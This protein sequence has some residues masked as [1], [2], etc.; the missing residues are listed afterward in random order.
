MHNPAKSFVPGLKAIQKKGDCMPVGNGENLCIRDEWTK[1]MVLFSWQ[2]C[3]D[4][5]RQRSRGFRA[6]ATQGQKPD[7]IFT[8]DLAD[9][10]RCSLIG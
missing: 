10:E 5:G 1:K 7:V 8:R 2:H 6:N 9:L 3:S 4:I